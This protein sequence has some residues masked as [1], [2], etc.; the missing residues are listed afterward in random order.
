MSGSSILNMLFEGE[1]LDWREPNYE[2]L[3][4]WC[5]ERQIHLQHATAKQLL[6]L[7]LITKEQW[8]SYFKFA[9]VRN[10]WD[11]SYSDYIW[12]Q[13]DRK[14]KV[15]FADYIHGKGQLAKFVNDRTTREYRGD[16]LTP[17]TDFIKYDGNLCVDL[18][19]RFE[20][21][22]QTLQT[23]KDKLGLEETSTIHKNKG[24][25]RAKHY[26]LFYTNSRKR[27]V[28]QIYQSDIEEFGYQFEDRRTGLHRIKTW[29]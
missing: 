4:G 21:Y 15:S 22:D 17:Q 9:F 20:D 14:I 23:V 8:D 27:L 12:I 19:G 2:K 26:S 11:K 6:E 3:Y 28:D 25:G 10:P 16:H 29:I 5:P 7:D 18:V 13:R 1:G 24:K